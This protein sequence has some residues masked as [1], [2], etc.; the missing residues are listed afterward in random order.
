MLCL[1]NSLWSWRPLC[2]PGGESRRSSM[3]FLLSVNLWSPCR[4][5]GVTPVPKSGLGRCRGDLLEAPLNGSSGPSG[6]R[7]EAGGWWGRRPGF[8]KASPLPPLD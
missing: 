6:V 5:V 1:T 7:A 2:S 4:G 3:G 8:C